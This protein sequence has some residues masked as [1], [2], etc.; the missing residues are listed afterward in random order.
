MVFFKACGVHK[1][2]SDMQTN[3]LINLKALELYNIHKTFK[4]EKES[5]SKKLDHLIN[6]FD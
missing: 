6:K 2:A 4:F 3:L 1:E 5:D